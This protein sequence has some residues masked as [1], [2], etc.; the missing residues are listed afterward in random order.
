MIA[1]H[2]H[3]VVLRFFQ[4]RVVLFDE[5]CPFDTVAMLSNI[6]RGSYKEAAM[7]PDRLPRIWLLQPET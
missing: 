4:G 6:A 3:V 2:K 1:P 7:H 5:G